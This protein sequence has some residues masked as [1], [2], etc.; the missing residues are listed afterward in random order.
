[1]P[2]HANQQWNQKYIEGDTPWDSGEVAAQLIELLRIEHEL[3][4]P[5]RNAL[6]IGCG[7]GTNAIALVQ[8]GFN[9]IA[10]DVAEQAITA[11]QTKAQQSGEGT[12]KGQLSFRVHDILESLPVEPGTVGLV[13]DR[14][15]FHTFTDDERPFALSAWP[16]HWHPAGGG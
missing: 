7:T 13:F 8:H 1:M 14:G 5:N 11:A 3:N 16:R 10:T 9:V 4:L 12:V 6:E 15:C 2:S